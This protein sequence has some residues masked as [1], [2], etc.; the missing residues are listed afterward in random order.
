MAYNMVKIPEVNTVMI[1]ISPIE[2]ILRPCII[3]GIKTKPI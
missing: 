3:R 1:I 2:N